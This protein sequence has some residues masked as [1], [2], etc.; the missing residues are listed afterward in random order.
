MS[1]KEVYIQNIDRPMNIYNYASFKY[2]SSPSLPDAIEIDYDMLVSS[3][4]ESTDSGEIISPLR[5][6][7]SGCYLLRYTP[8]SIGRG[9]LTAHYDGTLRIQLD[10]TNIIASG[11]LYLHQ[12]SSSFASPVNAEPNPSQGIPIFSRSNY[13]YYI[14]V[15]RLQRSLT[16]TIIIF[17]QYRYEHLNKW[18]N[19]GTFKVIMARIPAPIGFPSSSDYFTGPITNSTGTI[20]GNLTMGWIS[21]YFRRAT[22]EIDRSSASEA[23]LDNGSGI[24]WRSVFNL[25]GWDVT[26]IQSSSSVSEPSGESWSDAEL[27][28]KMLSMRDSSDLDTNWRYHILCV[29]KLDSTS[30][31]I[32]YDNSGTDSNNIPREGVGI[33]SHWVI[34]NI[35]QWGLV[36]G[37]RFGIAFAPYFRT[38]LHEIGHAMGLYHNTIDNGIM[39]TTD[40]IANNAVAPIQFPNNIQWSHA[41]DDQNRLRHLPDLWVRPG[42]IPF[43]STY[44]SV[45]PDDLILEDQ[46]LEMKVFPEL[47]TVPFGAPVRVNF[48]L[49]N[50]SDE[51]RIIPNEL[52]LKKGNISG[53]VIDPSG[54]ERTYLSIILCLDEE[55]TSA[56][57]KG[58]SRDGSITLLRGVQ[59][60]LF[61]LAGVY[62]IVVEA[63]WEIN[64][65]KQ[66]SI[67]ATNVMVTPP[68]D[69]EH[70]K[71]AY[72]IMS[73]PDSLLVLV[74]GGDH[75]KEGIDAIQSGLENPILR[76]HYEVI[77]AKRLSKKFGKRQPDIKLASKIITKK[78]IMSSTE[79]ESLSK[80]IKDVKNDASSD[81]IKKI[82]EV[83]KSRVENGSTT[84][85]E[86]KKK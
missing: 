31:G 3:I 67:G 9:L 45:I 32:M 15:V 5:S 13:R 82:N 80:T 1:K 28:S 6:I 24:D 2:E 23:P 69:D 52:S 79:A 10:G 57:G 53:K 58:E 11:D 25:V 26:I 48:S 18:I 27:H 65:L 63:S 50:N 54:T 29:R 49:L 62:K 39:N 34:P 81:I 68:V 51:P 66:R 33:S 43:G 20:V 85:R 74:I 75:L 4:Q 40:T 16:N 76:P 78:T 14:Q 61:P 8:L 73:N 38:A 64:G 21:K 30:R 41:P 56:I 60:A 35:N 12:I 46:S 71:A 70:A 47:E 83:L 17:K 36:K 22:I 59:G 86:R 19:E 55:E 84:K 7:K 44:P 72:K 37:L 77:E 42:G